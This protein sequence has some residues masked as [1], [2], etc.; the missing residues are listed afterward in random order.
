MQKTLSNSGRLKNVKKRGVFAAWRVRG[1]WFLSHF[2]SNFCKVASETGW[3]LHWFVERGLE[4][5]GRKIVVFAWFQRVEAHSVF[6]KT[7]KTQYVLAF[8]GKSGI[9]GVLSTADVE[10]RLF[11]GVFVDFT[12]GNFF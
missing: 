10:K 8:L 6:S 9:H 7:W 2:W 4:V 3:K 1:G 11:Y 12:S 5:I